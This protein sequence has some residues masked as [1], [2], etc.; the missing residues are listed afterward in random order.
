VMWLRVCRLRCSMAVVWC[1]DGA[2]GVVALS[3]TVFIVWA[4]CCLRA[5]DDD[6]DATG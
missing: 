3:V 5:D 2:D 6:D 4:M 1:C